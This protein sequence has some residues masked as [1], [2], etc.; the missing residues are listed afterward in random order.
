MLLSHADLECLRLA[1]WCKDLPQNTTQYLHADTV[2]H[3]VLVEY[4]RKSK[5]GLSYRL[6]DKGYDVLEQAGYHF[7]RDK[8]YLGKSKTLSRRLELAE[9]TLF[10]H[11]LDAD[12][13][14]ENATQVN[15]ALCFMPSFAIRRAKSSNVLGGT[16]LSG[17][18]YTQE[19]VLVPYYI[20]DGGIYPNV[21]Q[22]T[23]CAEYLSKKKKPVVI[24]TGKPE[25]PALVHAAY[26]AEQPKFRT[27]AKS[28]AQSI[29]IFLYPVCFVPLSKNGIRQLRIMCQPDYRKTLAK[30]LLQNDGYIESDNLWCD[31]INKKHG[32]PFLVGFDFNLKGFDEAVKMAKGKKL[33]IAV[34]DFQAE[35]ATKYL[36]S[37]KAKAS[38]Y[39]IEIKLVEDAL[40]LP[41][42]LRV[43]EEITP[44]QTK[45]G[46]YI[47][48]TNFETDRKA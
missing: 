20:S 40:D 44:Y 14:I 12:V 31:A 15:P 10:L 33:H 9:I 43:P 32:E 3:L 4:L 37:K 19:N 22:Q 18:L 1:A 39:P 42:G 21:E 35:D 26:H 16:R 24:Y 5:C 47:S 30:I 29:D 7:D 17:F 25:L 6:T 11:S 8:Q 38:I 34:L 36:K 41:A 46:G 28:F 27:K 2:T 13:F 23:F 45:E 48:V